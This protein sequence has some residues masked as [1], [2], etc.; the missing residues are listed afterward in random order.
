MKL[1]V[2]SLQHLARN[3]RSDPETIALELVKLARYPPTFSYAPLFGATR[4]MLVFGQ[5]LS[6][7]E[8]GFERA[9]A[10]E[11]VRDNLLGALRL[12][13]SHFHEVSPAFVNAVARRY[14]P[15]ARELMVPF[16]P[17]VL[18]GVDGRIEFPWLSFWK[19]NPLADERLA[20]FVT[21]VR[22]LLAQDPDLEDAAFRIL[23]FSAPRRSPDRVLRVID[24][25]EIA[26]VGEAKKREMLDTFAEGFRLA[27]IELASEPSREK[28]DDLRDD[29]D[30]AD[31]FKPG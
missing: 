31:L 27:E 11:D 3:W 17:P 18:Y 13:S 28:R 16:E 29:P 30:Q 4:D 12:L 14:Y 21:L 24:T 6:E 1:R 26:S 23:D 22:E 8:R 10:R 15:V 25:R 20:L 5:P 7:I 9:I 2:P 19:S